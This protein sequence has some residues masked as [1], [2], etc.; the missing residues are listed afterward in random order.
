MTEAAIILELAAID[1]LVLWP[2]IGRI[3][4]VNILVKSL[5]SRQ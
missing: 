1:Q 2:L 5:H 4:P 3:F